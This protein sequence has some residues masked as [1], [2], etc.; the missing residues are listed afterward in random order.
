MNPKTELEPK[1]LEDKEE[2]AV[3]RWLNARASFVVAVAF[4]L[5]AARLFHLI[6]KYA[7]NLSFSDLVIPAVF[8]TLL[9]GKP[10]WGLPILRMVRSRFSSLCF[11]VWHGPQRK[12]RP[13][14]RWFCSLTL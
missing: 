14:T 1:I 2:S 5:F 13:D 3:R 7:V 12:R 10:W 9:S 8:F 11:I 6:S 4:V